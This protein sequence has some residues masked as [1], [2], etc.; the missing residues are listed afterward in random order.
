MCI[1]TS[2]IDVEEVSN[3]IHEI[4]EKKSVCQE[5]YDV[6]DTLDEDEEVESE[7]LLIGAAADLVAAL[8]EAVGE[9]YASYFNVFLPLISKYYASANPYMAKKPYTKRSANIFRNPQS[10]RRIA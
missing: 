7:S 4:F 10:P 6:E 1:L 2:C 3:R 8:C 5:T 9:S